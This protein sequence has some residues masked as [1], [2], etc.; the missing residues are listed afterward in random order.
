[1]MRKGAVGL[2]RKYISPGTLQPNIMAD[3]DEDG[4]GTEKI[5]DP[6]GV[7][8]HPVL[9]WHDANSKGRLQPNRCIAIVDGVV[10]RRGGR[11]DRPAGCYSLQLHFIAPGPCICT[12]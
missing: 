7:D 1:M 4:L 2:E 3:A 12:S 9:A 5:R 6:D 10:Y 11:H 8:I